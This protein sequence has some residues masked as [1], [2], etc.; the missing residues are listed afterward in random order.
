MGRRLTLSQAPAL[1]VCALHFELLPK[2]SLLASAARKHLKCMG[3]FLLLHCTHRET[4]AYD[5]TCP[6]SHGKQGHRAF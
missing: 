3:W 5:R 6:K 1:F 2:L 4:E